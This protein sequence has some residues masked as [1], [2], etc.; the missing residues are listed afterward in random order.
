MSIIFLADLLIGLLVSM[1]VWVFYGTYLEGTEA[2]IVAM[3][4]FVFAMFMFFYEPL[5]RI[6]DKITLRNKGHGDS[7]K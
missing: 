7:V 6:T 4:L 1:S 5:N 3:I 2:V